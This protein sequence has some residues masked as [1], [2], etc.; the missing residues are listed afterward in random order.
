MKY[1][2]YIHTPYCVSKCAYCAFFSVCNKPDW[3][4]YESSIIRDLLYWKQE[5][6]DIEFQTIYF[7]GGTPSL[8]PEQTFERI[9]NAIKKN[10][11]IEKN[12]EISMESNPKTLGFDKLKFFKEI[13]LNRLS[14]GVQSLNDENLKFLGRIHTA[15]EARD[16]IESGKKLFEN[17]SCDFIYGLPNQ[18]LSEFEKELE[19][20]KNLGVQH[21]SLYELSIEE[22]SILSKQ[23]FKAIDSDRGMNFYSAIENIC[24]EYKR[25][26]IS[27]YAKSG[28]EC[29]HNKNIWQGKAYI[30]VGPAS[31]GR[32]LKNDEWYETYTPAEI[33]NWGNNPTTEIKK[34][35]EKER[36]EE[37]IIMGLR[38]IY[39]LELNEEI[40]KI[41]D[42]NYIKNNKQYFN[43]K[44]NQDN[45]IDSDSNQDNQIDLDSNKK[46]NSNNSETL[47]LTNSGRLVLDTLL[48]NL[49]K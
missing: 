40:K 30:G 23:G 42:F 38:T 36:N 21:L 47:S 31:A 16:F 19:E 29:K 28:F 22:N 37:K 24:K 4:K 1:Q 12:A 10:F 25:Y 14:I 8:M 48:P 13:G 41:I 18:K 39:G 34:L 3:E 7:G 32:I 27:N 33:K 6:S 49:I 5:I 43:I 26:E 17:I 35:S 2:L 15:K 11:Q 44:S 45:Q 20:I 46:I 9:M